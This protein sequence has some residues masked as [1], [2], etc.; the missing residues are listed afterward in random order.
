[1]NVNRFFLMNDRKISSG[2]KAAIKAAGTKANL[3]RACGVTPQTI[4]RWHQIPRDRIVQLEKALGVPR[5]TLAPE[6]YK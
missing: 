2:L 3:A 5:E 4:Q 6:L 1:M